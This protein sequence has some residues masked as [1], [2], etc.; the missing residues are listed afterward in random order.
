[1][2]VFKRLMRRARYVLLCAGVLAVALATAPGAAMAANAPLDSS[3]APVPTDG[4]VIGGAPLDVVFDTAGTAYVSN[5]DY[6]GGIRVIPKGAASY[7]RNIT[8]GHYVSS[9]AIGADNTLYAVQEHGDAG[10]SEIAVIA[11][12]GSAVA[13]TIALESGLG[14]MGIAP[15]GTLYIPNRQEK[16]VSV[17][18]PGGTA[19]ARTVAVGSDGTAYVANLWPASVSV[20]PPGS[21]TVSRTISLG[22][23]QTPHGIAV[24]SDGTLY[25][26]CTTTKEVLEVLPGGTKPTRSVSV[27]FNPGQVTA[28]PDGII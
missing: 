7:T 27:G 10:G 13:R 28:A 8:T 20:I 15:D 12:G 1:M 9:L 22:D 26:G 23:V 4:A 24:T 5:Y 14:W 6:D 21:A 17:V 18:L 16:T 2:R 25:V 3:P 19:I 11:P